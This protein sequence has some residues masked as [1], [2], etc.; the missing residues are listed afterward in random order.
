[1]TILNQ[2][3]TILSILL[4]S[5]L[6]GCMP[7][8]KPDLSYSEEKNSVFEQALENEQWV[9]DEFAE[10]K[11]RRGHKAFA[12]AVINNQVY[13]TGF[14]DDKITMEWAETEA[15]RMCKHY[16]QGVG[17]CE[18]VDKVISNGD[19]GLSEVE[20]SKAPKE[21][22]AHRDIHHF[23][24]YQKAKAPKAFVAAACSGQAFWTSNKDSKKQAEQI[25]LQ[26]C[27]NGRHA[28]DPCCTLLQSE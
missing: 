8:S 11:S 9:Q 12:I 27:E 6:I 5:L 28:S 4:A 1:M 19:H 15:L 13:A 22:I 18:I 16:S 2:A 21:L 10:Y 26:S 14:G 20:I 7:F 17:E 23:L 25:A 24:R 3:R